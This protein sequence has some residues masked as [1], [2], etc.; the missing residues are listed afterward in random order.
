MALV[1]LAA[2]ICQSSSNAMGTRWSELS[3]SPPPPPSRLPL[4]L[5]AELPRD[6][7]RLC[8]SPAPVAAASE[9]FQ[10]THAQ[11][12]LRR[13]RS[14]HGEQRMKETNGRTQ[15]CRLHLLGVNAGIEVCHR[16]LAVAF[17][18]RAVV[19]PVTQHRRQS[20]RHEVRVNHFTSCS[21]KAS[22][23]R[24]QCGAIILPGSFLLGVE[25]TQVHVS[26]VSG[27]TSGREMSTL[28]LGEGI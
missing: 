21:N 24:T 17:D 20:H 27:D 5:P 23:S 16:V 1:L 26:A 10:G 19:G 28:L 8:S 25:Q 14:T 3:S 7:S 15:G 11:S 9:L 2:A 12:K 22:R 6:R 4:L 18:G 13:E